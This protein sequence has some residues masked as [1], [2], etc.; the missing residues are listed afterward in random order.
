MHLD[1]I[2][3]LATILGPLLFVIVIGY[4]AWSN[5]KMSTRDKARSEQGAREL[6]DQLDSETGPTGTGEEKRG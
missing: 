1:S 5:R 2:Y 4:F 6:R 3:G